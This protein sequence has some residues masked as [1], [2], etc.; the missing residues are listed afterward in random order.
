MIADWVYDLS[1]V[2][3]SDPSG[4]AGLNKP[5]IKLSYDPLDNTNSKRHVAGIHI[6]K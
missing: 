1:K 5:A 3:L 6:K 4:N 2:N